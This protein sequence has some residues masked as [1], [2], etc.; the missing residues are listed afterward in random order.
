M[1]FFLSRFNT[2]P[3]IR[4]PEPFTVRVLDFEV[5]GEPLSGDIYLL[6]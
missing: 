2:Y 4:V 5:I 3:P 1:N 6:C